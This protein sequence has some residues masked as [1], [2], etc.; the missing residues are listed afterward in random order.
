MQ[1]KMRQ[2]QIIYSKALTHTRTFCKSK[3]VYVRS[4]AVA[5]SHRASFRSLFYSSS[6]TFT[7]LFALISFKL[8]NAKV[9]IPQKSLLVYVIAA[10]VIVVF[11]FTPAA[12]FYF[13]L[14][15][16]THKK[17]IPICEV[18]SGCK[19]QGTANWRA[20]TKNRDTPIKVKINYIW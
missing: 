18:I 14:C 16:I 20:N 6:L 10:A 2:Q 5:F 12:K 15:E 19:G 1:C 7:L 11:A 4:L 17:H 3:S 8:F 13:S 9:Q